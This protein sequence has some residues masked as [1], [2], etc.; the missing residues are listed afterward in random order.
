MTLYFVVDI[1]FPFENWN[2]ASKNSNRKAAETQRS[3]SNS[4]ATPKKSDNT[5]HRNQMH[6]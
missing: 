5:E 4:I 2:N 3:L 6:I 1:E